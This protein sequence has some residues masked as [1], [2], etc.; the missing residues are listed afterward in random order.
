MWDL[1]PRL[2]EPQSGEKQVLLRQTCLT[3]PAEGASRPS[4]GFTIW[5]GVGWDVGFEPTT[6]RTTI[7]RETGVTS[8]NLLNFPGRR[9]IASQSRIHDLEGGGVGCGI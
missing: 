5:R 4:R 9:C 2:P 3:F 8:S 6:S 1:N 7:W